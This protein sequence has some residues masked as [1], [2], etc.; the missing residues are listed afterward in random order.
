MKV[1]SWISRLEQWTLKLIEQ[2]TDISI[3]PQSGRNDDGSRHNVSYL[4]TR[5]VYWEIVCHSCEGR[6]PANWL[7][8]R[9]DA[10]LF[11]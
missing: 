3:P 11:K 6:N 2:M 4:S 1:K 5:G 10:R 9:L 8:A 7:A